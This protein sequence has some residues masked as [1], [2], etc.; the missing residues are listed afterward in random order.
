MTPV[1]GIQPEELDIVWPRV[2][3]LI[4]SALRHSMRGFCLDE[5]K[6]E[7]AAG[8]RQLWA[9]WPDCAAAGVTQIDAYPGSKVMTIV[10]FAGTMPPDWRDILR[11]M[12][13]HAAELGC[14]LI[15]LEGRPGWR[16][17]L[18]AEYRPGLIEFAKV[19]P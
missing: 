4:A 13:A 18:P 14:G 12:E 6:A 9:T 2:A 19:I 7:I 8:K 11:R 3:G 1:K 5:I 15:R 17:K 10:A 16:R